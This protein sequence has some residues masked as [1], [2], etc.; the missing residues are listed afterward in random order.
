MADLLDR[1]HAD[2]ALALLRADTSLTVYPDAEGN[3]PPVGARADRYVL[4]YWTISR[5][6]TAEGNAIDGR[7]QVWTTTWYTHAVGPNAYSSQ[8]VAMRVNRAL[9]DQ[10][11]TIAGRSVN[12]ITQTAE[13]PPTPSRDEETGAAVFD[14]AVAYEMVTSA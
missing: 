5:P 3:I 14:T 6:R 12:P 1:Q 7:S 9:A 2:A 13:N 10:L 8:A 4:V 11:P